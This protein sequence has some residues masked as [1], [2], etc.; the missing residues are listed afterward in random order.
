MSSEIQE[1]DTLIK[2]AKVFNNGDDPVVQD[3]AIANGKIIARGKAIT[4]NNV[5]R[6]VDAEG[7]WLMPGLFDICLLYTSPSPRDATL[8]RMP[9][10]A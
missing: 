7:L 6:V 10:S 4:A 8:S 2:N 5:G 1:I 3:V 9:S